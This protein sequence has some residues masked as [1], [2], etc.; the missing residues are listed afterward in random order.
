DARHRL[1]E[2]QRL[3]DRHVQ[4]LGD[5]LALVVHL[6][7]LPVVPGAVADLARHVDVGQEVHLDLDGACARAV[8][9][10]ATLDV[11]GEPTGQVP[12]D[13]GL[14]RLGEQ[15]ADVVE[16]AGVCGGVRPG[17]TADRRLVDVHDLVHQVVAVH[18][19]V[20]A[21]DAAR[22]VQLP[23]QVGVQD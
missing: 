11:E 18:P 8:P 3:L 10:A 21:G 6:Q 5:G 1:E 20:A 2:V 4:H 23:G 22:A 16:D 17:G 12:A 15:L 13:L 7:R 9:A 14:H 19:G